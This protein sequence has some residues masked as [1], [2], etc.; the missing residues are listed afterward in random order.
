MLQD[1]CKCRHSEASSWSNEENFG[2]GRIVVTTDGRDSLQ[3]FV[4]EA[5]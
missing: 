1:F 4:V 2:A 3:H 5:G